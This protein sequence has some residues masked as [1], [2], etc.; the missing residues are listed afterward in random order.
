MSDM[1]RE[2]SLG[3]GGGAG[4]GDR[5]VVVTGTEI[6]HS[7]KICLLSSLLARVPCRFWR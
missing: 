5:G 3:L 6:S 2:N 7:F 4:R 1:R